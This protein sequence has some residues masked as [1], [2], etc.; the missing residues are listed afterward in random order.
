MV[1][2]N[3]VD[4]SGQY[5]FMNPAGKFVRDDGSDTPEADIF[6]D[7]FMSG[8]GKIWNK[9]LPILKDYLLVGCGSGLF[10]TAYPQDNYIYSM[11]GSSDYDVKPHN[12]YLQ[13]WVE[14]GLPFLLLMLAF[15]IMY[16]VKVI[17][18][19]I[20]NKED[21]TCAVN[22]RISLG[23]MLA[24][25]VYLVSGFVNDSMIVYSPVFWTFLGLGMA[26]GMNED[27]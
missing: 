23:C 7:N 12:M 2:C 18:N 26:T 17:K 4:K 15:F 10:I 5:Y 14:E 9:T 24:V 8:R 16:Y 27:A 6:P 1:I 22:R 13:Y 20:K 25:T 19:Y 11:Y 3:Q 21:V